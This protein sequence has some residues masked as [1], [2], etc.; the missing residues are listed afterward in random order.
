MGKKERN[1]KVFS[2]SNDFPSFQLFELASGARV[3][4]GFLKPSE[5]QDRTAPAGE[6]STSQACRRARGEAGILPVVSHPAVLLE[7][8]VRLAGGRALVTRLEEA[9]PLGGQFGALTLL[10]RQLSLRLREREEHAALDLSD[11]DARA[12]RGAAG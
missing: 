4:L 12:A 3:I 10:L 8:R 1:G 5:T 6:S 2:Y 9:R 11:L 7:G